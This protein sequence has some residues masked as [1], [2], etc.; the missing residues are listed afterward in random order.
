MTNINFGD[1]KNCEPVSNADP[2]RN[3]RTI[4]PSLK[5]D[6]IEQ[7]KKMRDR[8]TFESSPEYS[9]LEETLK[10]N[11]PSVD[12]QLYDNVESCSHKDNED[13]EELI[14]DNQY[15]VY[16]NV[17]VPTITISESDS[18]QQRKLKPPVPP[19]P[20]KSKNGDILSDESEKEF[21]KKSNTFTKDIKQ[22]QIMLE[23]KCKLGL[24]E[25]NSLNCIDSYKPNDKKVF[26]FRKLS[27]S[28]SLN[29]AINL[30]DDEKVKKI[31]P[32]SDDLY[33]PMDKVSSLPTN[34]ENKQNP[35]KKVFSD[36]SEY[37]FAGKYCHHSKNETINDSMYVPM[38]RRKQFQNRRSIPDLSKH[39]VSVHTKGDHC[40][41]YEPLDYLYHYELNPNALRNNAHPFIRTKERANS[42]P[43]ICQGH[44]GVTPK[45][46]PKR[47]K[48]KDVDASQLIYYSCEDIYV[49]IT[50]DYCSANDSQKDEE[51]EQLPN[52]INKHTEVNVL[53]DAIQSGNVV[54]KP[55]NENPSVTEPENKRNSVSKK[56][57]VLKKKFDQ[58]KVLFTD[59][60]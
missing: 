30:P 57:L 1:Y 53:D 10:T 37:D 34:I 39:C 38:D 18:S 22:Q 51:T 41:I 59:W 4:S 15:E 12:Y 5:Q 8:F 36:A 46:N 40:C 6:I 32:L 29:T 35:R 42:I 26:P 43:C 25:S 49:Q 58:V 47:E 27:D 56:I 50:K 54:F 2:V 17:D 60:Q 13:I 19:K 14:D 45:I 55:F 28:V 33:M 24:K 21:S 20:P 48:K 44:D 16:Q 11:N 31:S 9:N 52:D 7:S 3:Y 23:I